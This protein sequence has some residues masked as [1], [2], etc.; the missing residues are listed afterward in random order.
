MNIETVMCWIWINIRIKVIIGDTLKMN[1]G[2]DQTK[3]IAPIKFIVFPNPATD[4][5]SIYNGNTLINHAEI[6]IYDISGKLIIQK[7]N[8]SFDKDSKVEIA[9]NE[10][11]DGLYFI[12]IVTLEYG[13]SFIKLIK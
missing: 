7:N 12:K 5:I 10:L 3:N 6:K 2:F 4:R 13:T 11:Q 9:I 8:I 1:T